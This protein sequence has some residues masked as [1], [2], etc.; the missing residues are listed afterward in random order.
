MTSRNSSRRTEREEASLDAAAYKSPTIPKKSLFV[1]L[2]ILIPWFVPP[3]WGTKAHAITWSRFSSYGFIFQLAT[4]MKR[5]M[6][7]CRRT[8]QSHAGMGDPAQ[9]QTSSWDCQPG[10][11]ELSFCNNSLQVPALWAASV[12]AHTADKE[13]PGIGKVEKKHCR[14]PGCKAVSRPS[15]R[16]ADG[17]CRASAALGTF[18]PARSILAETRTGANQLC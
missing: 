3:R 14:C 1:L 18:S 7:W 12:R 9:D 15:Q 10:S 2:N 4:V 16:R 5:M 6:G 8:P 17:D 13:A 11:A